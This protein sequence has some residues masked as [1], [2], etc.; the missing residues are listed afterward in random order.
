MLTYVIRTFIFIGIIIALNFTVTQLKA[1][2][3]HSPW[4]QTIAIQVRIK[5]LEVD[6]YI[7]DIN[8]YVLHGYLITLLPSIVGPNMYP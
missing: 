1:T 3:S 6:V 5:S 2:L 8:T 7:L 4:T